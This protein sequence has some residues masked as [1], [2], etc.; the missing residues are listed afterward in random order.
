MRWLKKFFKN[1]LKP[2]SRFY[3][4]HKNY[5][6]KYQTDNS[7]HNFQKYKISHIWDFLEK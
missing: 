3:H 2:K 6:K 7:N 5:Q 4:S 1:F